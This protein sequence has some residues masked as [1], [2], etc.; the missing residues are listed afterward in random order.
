MERVNNL[1]LLSS[2]VI[3]YYHFVRYKMAKLCKVFILLASSYI[4]NY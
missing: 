3:V 2:I 1:R 4:L